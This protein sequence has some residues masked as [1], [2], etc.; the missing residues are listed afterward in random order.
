[1]SRDVVIVSYVRTPFG[2]FGGALRDTPSIELAALVMREALRRANLPPDGVEEVYY[3]QAMPGEAALTL[4][5]PAR[6][7]TLKAGL[8]PEQVSITL[9]RACCSSMTAVR[10]AARAIAGGEIDTALAVGADNMSRAPFLLAPGLRWGRPLGHLPLEDNLFELGY[11]E[12]NPVAVDAGEVA[13]EHGVSREEQDGWAYRSQKRYQE[14]LAAGKFSEEI[15][16]VEVPQARGEPVRVERDEFPKPHSTPEKLASLKTI[17][18]SPTVTPGNAPGLDAGAAALLLM[19]AERAKA[20]GT[21]VLARITAAVA[22]ATE[23]RLIASIPGYTIGAALERA[24]LAVE[25]VDLFEINEAF[26]AMPL[27]SSLILAGGDRA[28]A[29]RLQERMNVNGGAVAIGHPVGASGARILG[30]LAL[31]L[32]RRGGGTGA[33]AI[34]GGLAQ[35]EGVIIQV[36]GQGSGPGGGGDHG[37]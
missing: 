36:D 4:N 22:T 13:L 31:E 28:R 24:G 9:D 10:L 3:G 19:S 26:A 5:V 27:V 32:R 20:T 14:A 15:V 37:R 1:M 18:G 34:C 2:K 35:G 30:T 11:R 23:P 16:P 21:P 12:F 17:Y 25:D 6:Q 33:A 29:L 7:A 8:P